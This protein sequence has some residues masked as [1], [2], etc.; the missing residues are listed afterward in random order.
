[1]IRLYDEL[2]QYRHI[3]WDMNGTLI[4]DADLCVRAVNP[5][6]IEKGLKPIDLTI[7]RHCF[8]FPVA[9]YYSDL[10]FNVTSEEFDALSHRFHDHYHAIL[11]EAQL[12]EGTGDL[13]V[14]LK[15]DGKTLSILTAAWHGDMEQVVRHYGIAQHFNH[16]YGLQH[17]L[18]DSKI[19]R[20][21]ELLDA[22]GI[23][24]EESVLLGDTLHDLEVGEALGIKTILLTEGHMSEERLRA[25]KALV[26]SRR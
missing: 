24:P 6:L 11:S 12:F 17:R 1:M 22:A 25:S 16:M 13:L 4:D 15:Q 18:A 21:R 9:D 14:K 8:R 19:Q 5:L 7:Y 26:I 2:S 3:I 10:G 23:R 20:G